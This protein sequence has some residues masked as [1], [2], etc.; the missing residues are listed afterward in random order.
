MFRI[1]RNDVPAES[2]NHAL[3]DLFWLV[4]RS[5]YELF[6]NANL[7]QQPYVFKGPVLDLVVTP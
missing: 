2:L 6:G 5:L 7:A 3:R 4:D 1:I